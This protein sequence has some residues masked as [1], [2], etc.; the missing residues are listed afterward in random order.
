MAYIKLTKIVRDEH[1]RE[2]VACI[3]FGTERCRIHSGVQDCAHCPMMLAIMNQLHEFES[4]IDEE[5]L[6]ERNE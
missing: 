6:N 5:E 4:L 3:D 1:E 2:R